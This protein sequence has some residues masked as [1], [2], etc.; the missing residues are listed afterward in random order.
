MSKSPWHLN[1]FLPFELKVLPVKTYSKIPTDWCVCGGFLLV[2]V[3][4]QS[5]W[6]GVKVYG[7]LRLRKVEEED[8]RK[9]E[10]WR[11]WRW[12]RSVGPERQCVLKLRT[13]IS[14]RTLF[15]QKQCFTQW[16]V[17]TGNLIILQAWSIASWCSSISSYAL[18][19]IKAT[20]GVHS[21]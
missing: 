5:G 6:G 13:E 16:V 19:G 20:L 10:Q 12:W 14:P 11:W 21:F 8:E 15:L 9:W 17:H 7:A 1:C 2:R 3:T 4:E 18:L